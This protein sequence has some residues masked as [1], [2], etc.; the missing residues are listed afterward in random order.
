[1]TDQTKFQKKLSRVRERIAEREGG[2]DEIIAEIARL[3]VRLEVSQAHLAEAK[4]QE[5]I[6][7]L[8]H[9]LLRSQEEVGRLLATRPDCVHLVYINDMLGAVYS[10]LIDEALPLLAYDISTVYSDSFPDRTSFTVKIYTIH[11]NRAS[12]FSRSNTAPDVVFRFPGD[13]NDNPS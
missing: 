3:D 4:A 12:L 9:D 2:R 13:Y 8:G 10:N 11:T 1:M 7:I 5:Q 6:A